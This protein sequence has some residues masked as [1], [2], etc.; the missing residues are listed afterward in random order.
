[1]YLLYYPFHVHHQS[2][3]VPRFFGAAA[4]GG[5]SFES[6]GAGDSDGDGTGEGDT[7]L[8][9]ED[10]PDDP[11]V[12]RA[13]VALALGA[14]VTTTGVLVGNADACGRAV[15]FDVVATVGVGVGVG[16]LRSCT[17]STGSC[18]PAEHA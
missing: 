2:I 15:G 4:I 16:S 3:L 8:V 1:M 6:I 11:P 12:V 14:A 13:A 7:A 9:P 17:N 18:G 5:V 10:V